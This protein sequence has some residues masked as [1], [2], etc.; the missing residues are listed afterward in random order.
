VVKNVTKIGLVLSGMRPIN[1]LVQKRS[2]RSCRVSFQQV[3]VEDAK[4]F[5]FWGVVNDV[6]VG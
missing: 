1:F 5:N 6:D 4:V 2:I 3:L